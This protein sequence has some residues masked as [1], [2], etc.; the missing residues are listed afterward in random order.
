MADL[1]RPMN[2]QHRDY[3]I[4]KF[5]ERWFDYVESTTMELQSTSKEKKTTPFVY[6]NVTI[7]TAP[8][9]ASG[10]D[11]HHEDTDTTDATGL[12]IPRSV[13]Q[14]TPLAAKTS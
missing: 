12:E 13:R 1:K 6:D 3:W 14:R 7:V 8:I 10:R 9:D 11:R 5:A 2:E 4:T